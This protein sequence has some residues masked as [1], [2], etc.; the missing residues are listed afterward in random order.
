MF[1]DI[2]DQSGSR[3]IGRQENVGARELCGDERVT[4]SNCN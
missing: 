4:F 1:D 3:S 2:T